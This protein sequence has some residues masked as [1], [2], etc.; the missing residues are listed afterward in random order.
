[1][2]AKT[3]A[4]LEESVEKFIG[5]SSASIHFLDRQSRLYDIRM[6][7]LSAQQED[8]Q[9]AGAASAGMASCWKGM[10]SKWQTVFSS[11]WQT[12]AT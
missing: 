4:N 2:S 7:A 11:G 5:K 8:M 12:V 9:C 1:V 6:A 10:F 3:G